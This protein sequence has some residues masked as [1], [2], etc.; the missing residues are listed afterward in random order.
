MIQK[1]WRLRGQE[2]YLHN[3]KFIFK[4]FISH[5]GCLHSHCE[6]C[7]HKFMESSNGLKD[8]SNE[9]YCTEDEKY[10]VCRE[11]FDDFREDF[12]WILISD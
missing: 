4:K 11:C 12:N 2:D 10:W 7:W 1:D 8:C 5:K 3:K 9:G 6:F